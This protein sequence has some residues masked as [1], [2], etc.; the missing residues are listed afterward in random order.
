MDPMSPDQILIVLPTG[1]GK[2]HIIRTVG[3]MERGITLIF[4][5]L[6]TLAADVMA[7]FERA[8]QRW[9]LI[10]AYHLDGLYDNSRQ[11]YHLLLERVTIQRST[12]STIFIFLSPQFLVEHDEA[13]AARV[14]AGVGKVCSNNNKHLIIVTR[15]CLMQIFCPRGA[16]CVSIIFKHRRGNWGILFCFLHSLDYVLHNQL[17]S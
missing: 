4:I 14:N 12:S 5:P 16:L 7:K 17:L 1:G 8:D 6:L 10:K 11:K 9:G 2:T 13:R 15:S 3:V